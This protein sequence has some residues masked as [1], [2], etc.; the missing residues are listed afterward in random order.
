MEIIH[1][2][3]GEEA[4]NSCKPLETAF[5]ISSGPWIQIMPDSHEGPNRDKKWEENDENNSSHAS[6]RLD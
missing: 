5:P 3:Y 2:Q 4:L 6:R 1:S